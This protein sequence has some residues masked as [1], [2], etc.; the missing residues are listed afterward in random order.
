MHLTFDARTSTV[1]T[2]VLL[3]DLRRTYRNLSEVLQ[4]Q[5]PAT[6]ALL[7]DCR[8]CFSAETDRHGPLGAP[9]IS[10]CTH[11]ALADRRT[12]RGKVDQSHVCLDSRSQA[13]E[14]SY[15]PSKGKGRP[16]T[17]RCGSFSQ[18]CLLDLRQR[19]RHPPFHSRSIGRPR[20]EWPRKD[21]SQ[22]ARG[23]IERKPTGL[24]GSLGR[25][26][27]RNRASIKADGIR[28][29]MAMS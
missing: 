25:G 17:I 18:S 14:R 26:K 29:G 27:I 16:S 11:R 28:R 12:V 1:G 19:R 10:R 22:S 15:D 2:G 24:V 9:R 5:F 6:R 8:Y 4:R 13:I 3:S 7:A 23:P 20:G 21:R